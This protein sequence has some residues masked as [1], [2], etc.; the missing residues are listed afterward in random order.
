MAAYIQGLIDDEGN[1][2]YPKTKNDAIYNSKG[3]PLSE[4]HF[5]IEGPIEFIGTNYTIQDNR[6]RSNAVVHVYYNDPDYDMKP[7]YTVARGSLSISLD[8]FPGGV[9]KVIIDAVE[10]VNK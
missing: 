5:V 4:Q 1:I 6:I 3:V 2:I 7:S 8:Q 10:V 9:N